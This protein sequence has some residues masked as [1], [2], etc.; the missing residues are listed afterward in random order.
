MS[1]I[2]FLFLCIADELHGELRG[3]KISYAFMSDGQSP[4]RE[5]RGGRHDSKR[6]GRSREQWWMEGVSGNSMVELAWMLT[7]ESDRATAAWGKTLGNGQPR[8]P[9]HLSPEI[10]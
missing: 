9:A 8:L 3:K 5:S 1:V 6:M 4:T 10:L 2:G 7:F